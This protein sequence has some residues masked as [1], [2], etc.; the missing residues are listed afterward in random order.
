M[1]DPQYFEPPAEP[2]GGPAPTAK[3]RKAY[4]LR[5][6][7]LA[8]QAV[9]DAMGCQ[10]G[11]ARNHVERAIERGLPALPKRMRNG[12]ARLDSMAGKAIASSISPEG[13]D[14]AKV[15]E[16]MEAIG[17]PRAMISGLVRR[18]KT[19]YRPVVKTLEKFN[20]D[21]FAEKLGRKADLIEE[22]MDE[23][24]IASSGLKDLSYA[25]SILVDKRQILAGK[26]TQIYDITV[27]AKLDALVPALITE[28]RRRGITIEGEFSHAVA[29]HATEISTATYGPRSGE[30]ASIRP[31]LAEAAMV[32]ESGGEALGN[33]GNPAIQS[34]VASDR[35]DLA[36]AGPAPEPAAPPP[37]A[38]AAGN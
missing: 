15:T 27:R 26:P 29:E 6:L 5:S 10:V 25:L 13:M 18:L 19:Q 31:E 36:V 12:N 34:A 1:T 9:A 30:D 17:M 20:A 23:A 2:Y 16:S 37:A 3:Q 8:W 35:P 14:I 32:D 4:E 38:L 22:Y 24:L 21:L 11:T 7:G 33:D 28:A